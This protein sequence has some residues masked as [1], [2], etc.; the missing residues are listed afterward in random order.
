[1]WDLRVRGCSAIAAKMEVSV[2]TIPFWIF[3]RPALSQELEISWVF[4]KH[5]VVDLPKARKKD[6]ATLTARALDI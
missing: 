6:S 1:L 3:P 4:L 2:S 5:P